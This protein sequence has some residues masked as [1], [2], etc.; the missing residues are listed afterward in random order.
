MFSGV[1]HSKTW[2]TIQNELKLQVEANMAKTEKQNILEE[3][4]KLQNEVR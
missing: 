4:K 3:L 1:T 2:L